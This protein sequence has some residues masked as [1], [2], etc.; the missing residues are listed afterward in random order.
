[1][2]TM[3][4]AVLLGLCVM[5]VIQADAEA[6]TLS[7]FK[8]RKLTTQLLQLYR[9]AMSD[10]GLDIEGTQFQVIR[11]KVV[12]NASYFKAYYTN[13][14]GMN[15]YILFKVVVFR[16]MQMKSYVFLLILSYPRRKFNPSWRLLFSLQ[17]PLLS[18]RKRNNG[19][20]V[21]DRAKKPRISRLPKV[22]ESISITEP[23]YL[24]TFNNALRSAGIDPEGVKLKSLGVKKGI[25]R[26]HYKAI[27]TTNQGLECSFKFSLGILFTRTGEPKCTKIATVA[28]PAPVELTTTETAT[29]QPTT[30]TTAFTEKIDRNKKV[31]DKPKKIADGVSQGIPLTRTE[32]PKCSKIATVAPLAPVELTTTTET[33][34]SQPTTA[35][36]AFTEKIDKNKKVSDKPKK[37]VEGNGPSGTE[38]KKYP[39]FCLNGLLYI[40]V[41]GSWDLIDDVEC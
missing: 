37:I 8:T 20:T 23:K 4:E 38:P 7:F 36:T 16:G 6:S 25:I 30:A 17:I 12:N 26:S 11:E 34:T 19:K 15:C 18:R 41:D 2:S 40:K 21:A 27:Y 3:L 10:A 33:A 13:K 29:S 39:T 35:T 9:E 28:P 31:S 1:M 14:M 5:A 22:Y 24:D 32:E